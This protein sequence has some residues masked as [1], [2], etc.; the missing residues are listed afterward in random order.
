MILSTGLASQA[1]IAEAVK[2]LRDS[3]CREP[4]LVTLRQRIPRTTCGHAP[5]GDAHAGRVV[6]VETGLSDH[7]MDPAVAVAAVA[8]GA[9]VIEKHFILDRKLGG[10]DASFS[11]EPDELGELVRQLRV[12]EAAVGADAAIPGAT[13][14]ERSNLAS[15]GRCSWSPDIAAG[16]AFTAGNVRAL[17]PGAGLPPRTSRELIGTPRGAG[18]Q[19]RHAAGSGI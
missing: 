11:L 9:S 18:D 4:L 10:P 16:E 14:A 8:L 6:D 12:A 19:A 5:R 2:V 3:G 7:T 1:E 13:D 15:G 17:R